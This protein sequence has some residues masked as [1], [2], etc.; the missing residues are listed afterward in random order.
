MRLLPYLINYIF[1]F[2]VG[3]LCYFVNLDELTI[4][5]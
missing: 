4:Q 3:L 5:L 1:E 2:F